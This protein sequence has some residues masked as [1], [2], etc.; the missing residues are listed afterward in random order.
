MIVFDASTLILLA[1]AELSEEFL[2][3]SKIEA[4][5]PREVAREACE[6]KETFDALLIQR[7][8][9]EKK[10]GVEAL[11]DRALFGKLRRE[12]RLGAGEAE[13]IALAV[14]KK[15]RIVA[16]D[17]RNAINACKLARIPFTSA[18]AVLVRMYGQRAIGKQEALVKL[19]TLEREGRYRKTMI[20]EVRARLEVG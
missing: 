15:A 17:D 7:L 4:V 11:K 1:K 14:E 9:E 8:I 12:L 20:A 2:E 6:V 19:A 16:T 5:V 18:L 13:A 10:I 3:A